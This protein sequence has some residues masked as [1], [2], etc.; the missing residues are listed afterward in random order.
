MARDDRQNSDMNALLG[1]G[2][3][4][5]GKLTFEGTVKIEGNFKGEILTDDILVVGESAKVDA[6]I[7]VGTVIVNGEINGNITAGQAVELHNPAKVRGNISTPSLYI[8]KGVT[9]EGACTMGKDRR[10]TA[11]PAG[12]KVEPI[13]AAGE[14][15]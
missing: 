11:A 6:E 5:E 1:R 7:K 8:E 9:F 15:K 13:A 2:A 10:P 12:A 3:S 4:F 14:K